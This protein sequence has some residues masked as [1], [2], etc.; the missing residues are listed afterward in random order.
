MSMRGLRMKSRIYGALQA[1]GISELA[2]DI[3]T[4]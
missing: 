4:H 2:Q 1:L 3:V